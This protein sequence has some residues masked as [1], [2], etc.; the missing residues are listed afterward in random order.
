[1]EQAKAHVRQKHA[2]PMFSEK[3]KTF[4]LFI[5]DKFC[6]KTLGFKNR[7]VFQRD[8]AF[9]KVQYFAGDRA[10][11]LGY[12]KG[13]E[14][15]GLPNGDILIS[16]TIGKCLRGKKANTFVLPKCSDSDICSGIM[17]GHMFGHYINFKHL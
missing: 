11:D 12:L 6:N 15:R 8:Q 1:M 3:L 16:H 9:F 7:Y 4:S 17:F 13:Q 14:L 10:G 5:D 2:K